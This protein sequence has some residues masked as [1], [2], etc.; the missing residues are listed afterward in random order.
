MVV[1]GEICRDVEQIGKAIDGTNG[2]A[3]GGVEKELEGCEVGHV[4]ESGAESIV[5]GSKKDGGGPY[6]EGEGADMGGDVGFFGEGDDEREIVG[7]GA[8]MEVAIEQLLGE[9]GTVVVCGG[10]RE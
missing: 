8:D 1:M 9:A 10:E 7:V 2:G 3:A 4:G 6:V 5:E